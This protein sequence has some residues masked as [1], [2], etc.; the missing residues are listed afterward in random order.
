MPCGTALLAGRSQTGMGQASPQNQTSLP[1]QGRQP[2][3]TAAPLQAWVPCV[4]RKPLGRW[5]PEIRL[6]P[7]LLRCQGAREQEG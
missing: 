7:L 5:G 6:P 1:S 2:Y 4:Q 3:L